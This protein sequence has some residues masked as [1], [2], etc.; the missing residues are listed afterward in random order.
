MEAAS[1][2]AKKISGASEGWKW[3]TEKITWRG[4]SLC[5]SCRCC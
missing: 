3:V 1:V 4:I 5:M 2:C